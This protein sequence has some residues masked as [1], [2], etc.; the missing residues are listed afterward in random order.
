MMI[1]VLK[2]VLVAFCFLSVLASMAMAQT[3]MTGSS[4]MGPGTSMPT[5]P[6]YQGHELAENMVVPQF[7]VGDQY[8][9]SILLF[10]MGNMTQ[11]SW[12]TP[13]ALQLTGKIY[14]YHQDGTPLQV[15]VNGSSPV[16]EYSFTLSDSGSIAL[17]MSSP[18]TVTAGWALITVNDDGSSSWGMMNG[19][20]MM[21]A[22]RIMA[23]A[24]YTFKDN[25]QVV[26]RAGVIPSIFEMQRYST[27]LTPV[28]VQ[29]GI[30]TGLAIVNTSAQSVTVQLML[31]DANGQTV[32]TRQLTLP[33]GNQMARFIDDAQLF[34]SAVTG[35]F[36]GFVQMDT[37]SEGV[38]S[39]GLLM[40]GGVMTSIPTQH[41]GPVTMF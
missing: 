36:H 30:D 40:T 39:L 2:K 16:S 4:M 3:G 31:K 35:T 8:T 7:A 23:T 11:M 25:G 27:S 24:Y 9:T 32:A 21:R 17:E 12:M 6:G 28:Q 10:N 15:S 1:S 18:G 5:M 41:H 19:Q 33:A 29:D 37:S 38:V 14:F 22:N 34:G 13:Q 26:S 20:Q